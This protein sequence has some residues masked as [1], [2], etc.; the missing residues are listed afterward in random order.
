MTTGVRS[1][2]EPSAGVRVA[3]L[4][5]VAAALALQVRAL[6]VPGGGDPLPFAH[7]DKIVHA[8]IFALPVL[9][10]GLTGLPWRGLAVLLVAHAPVSE[11][12]QHRWL[13]SRTGDVW[14]LLADW[15]GLALACGLVVWLLPRSSS[16]R[17]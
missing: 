16:A 11:Y 13:E 7:A 14:D 9:I 6:Y 15:T 1:R 3:G 12:V 5:L 17:S 4:V 2:R 10:A 8:A